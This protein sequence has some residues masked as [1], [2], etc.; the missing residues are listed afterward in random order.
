MGRHSKRPDGRELDGLPL[1]LDLNGAE[2]RGGSL[3]VEVEGGSKR[4]RDTALPVEALM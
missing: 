1:A 3:L 4:S 2:Y